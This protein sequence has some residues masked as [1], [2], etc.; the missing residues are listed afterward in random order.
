MPVVDEQ[1]YMDPYMYNS[2]N[3]MPPETYAFL[4]ALCAATIVQLDAAIAVP[5]ME[6]LPGRPTSAAEMFI[7][8]CLK[9]RQEVD[10]IGNP[11]TVTV[12]TSFFIFAYYGNKENGDKAWHYLQESISFIETLEMDDEN[13]MLKL[14]QLEAQ[15]RRRL[16]WLLFIT[17]RY[18]VFSLVFVFSSTDTR[19][20][21]IFDTTPQ[22]LPPAS[23]H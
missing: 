17:E 7:E 6:P 13:S 19:A 18:F 20:Q 15:W 11:T 14:D 12:M 22:E 5:E 23:Y 16:Y 4:C 8:E 21:S 3:Y 2:T 1:L 10:Y 9:I